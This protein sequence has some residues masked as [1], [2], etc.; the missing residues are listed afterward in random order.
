MARASGAFLFII[1]APADARFAD[2]LVRGLALRGVTGWAQPLAS[3][4]GGL[5]DPQSMQAMELASAVLLILSPAAVNA[6]HVEHELIVAA[7]L[8][9]PVLVLGKARLDEG[10]LAAF[11]TRAV[12]IDANLPGDAVLDR[13]EEQVHRLA[14]RTRCHLFRRHGRGSRR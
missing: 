13:I 2:D 14:R 10:R 3:A 1:R 11:L 9:R 6:E 12:R 7:Q 8:A 5:L 4:P